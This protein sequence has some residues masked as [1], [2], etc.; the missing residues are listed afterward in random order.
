MTKVL[1]WESI[2]TDSDHESLKSIS[3]PWQEVYLESIR[4]MGPKLK[5]GRGTGQIKVGFS[6]SLPQFLIGG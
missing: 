2:Y 4:V 5:Q 1:F 6:V 3:T